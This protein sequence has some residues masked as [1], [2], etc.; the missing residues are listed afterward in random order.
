MV[1][2][3]MRKLLEAGVHFG[4]QT[5]RWNPKMSP[6]IFMKR[7]GIHIIDLQKTLKCMETARNAIRDVAKS[8]KGILFVCTKKQGKEIVEGEAKRCGMH[9]VTERWLGGML[10]NFRTIRKSVG[11]LIEIENMATDGTFQLLTKK[12]ILGIQ[13]EKKKLEKVLSGI[14]DMTSLPGLVFVIDTRKERIAVAESRRVEVPIVGVLD[15]NSDPETIDYPIPGNDD[16]IRSIRLFS[17][18]AADAVLE[19]KQSYLEGLDA[20]E[21]EPQEAEAEA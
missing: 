3:D 21:E 10:T 6:Y 17:Q 5:E 9:Y 12:E 16:A 8:G 4:H 1:S 20:T 19:G 7:N 18:F 2:I 15:T 11:R 14:R 13:K